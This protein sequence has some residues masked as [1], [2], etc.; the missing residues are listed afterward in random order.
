MGPK[1]IPVPQ[2]VWDSTRTYP[3]I[4]ILIEYSDTTFSMTDPQAYYDSVLNVPGFNK[5]AGPGCA[6]EYLEAQS[7]G[8]MHVRFDVFGPYRINQK[9]KQ[10]TGPANYGHTV[11]VEA[12]D[13]LYAAH[14]TM[15]YTVYDWDGDNT[16][17]QA[18]Y[19][20]AG[21][22]GSEGHSACVWPNTSDYPQFKKTP[23][24]L[25]IRMHSITAEGTYSSRTHSGPSGFG[26]LMHEFSHALGLPDVYPTDGNNASTIYSVA[27]GWDLM[28]GGDIIAYG[29]CPPNYTAAE[30]M[31]MHWLTPVE[32]DTDTMITGMLP[33]ADGGEA[34][35]IRHTA[36]EYLL[37]ENR[38]QTGWDHGIPGRGLT[39]W[40]VDYNAE[41]WRENEVNNE[42]DLGLSLYYADN[43][44][45][46]E[47]QRRVTSEDAYTLNPRMRSRWLSTA[48]YPWST[49]STSWVN[50]GLT[51]TSTPALV[52]H[53]P[54]GQGSTSLGKRITNIQMAV[55]GSISF[56]LETEGTATGMA[57]D[58]G[59]RAPLTRKVIR[60]GRLLIERGEQTYTITGQEIK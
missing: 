5:G 33:L 20:C 28:D 43:L 13:S 19:V 3:Q 50:D 49:D 54:N 46:K 39:I 18:I 14:P 55:D 32:L 58:T 12:L 29:W 40:H 2:A 25:S 59:D 16:I 60:D 35:L 15:D 1:R 53:H 37:L 31:L 45:Y 11:K 4:V 22:S 23:D 48:A 47:W 36:N 10:W 21:P 44:T 8:L 57:T 38:Q 17:E 26:T 6:A 34:Y 51:E 42:S 30:R 52:M 24:S 41:S 56:T 7:G 9:A 27:D